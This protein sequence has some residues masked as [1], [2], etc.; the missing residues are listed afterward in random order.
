M[1]NKAFTLIELLVVIAIIGVLA[2][3]V[4]VNLSSAQNK[5][6]TAKSL[7]HSQSIHNALG[8]YSV[9]VWNFDEGSGNTAKDSSGYGNH[10]TIHGAI[11]TTETPLGHGHA[12]SFNGSNNYVNCGNKA[13]LSLG[14]QGTISLWAK[15]NRAFPSNSSSYN[16][17]GLVGKVIHGGSGGQSYFIDWYG[18]NTLRYLRFGIGNSTG[19]TS[20]TVNFDFTNEWKNILVIWGEERMQLWVNGDLIRSISNNREPQVINNNLN[21]GHVFNRWD[22]SIDDVRIYKE[23]LQAS[24]I[25]LLYYAGLNNLF[26]KGLIT[27]EEYNERL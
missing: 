23:A 24:E 17:R 1:K 9:G 22:G 26:A 21:I 6:K 2:S 15:S 4:L 8:A 19:L 18:T 7:Q 5:A 10:G 27:E 11:Y 13:S 20:L 16:Y 25:Q 14:N 12:L 3:I